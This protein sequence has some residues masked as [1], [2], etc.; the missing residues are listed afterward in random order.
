MEFT[1]YQEQAMLTSVYKEDTALM[2]PALKLA[3][4]AGEFAEK[5]GKLMRDEGW[6]PGQAITPEKINELVRELGD[7]LWYIAAAARDLG[8]TIDDVAAVNVIKLADRA[9][10]GALQGSGDAR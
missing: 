2:Y 1:A 5:V 9:Q 7:V 4:E 6:R 3:G 8:V 10:R